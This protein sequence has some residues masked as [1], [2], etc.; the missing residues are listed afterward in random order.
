MSGVALESLYDF[1]AYFVDGEQADFSNLRLHPTLIVNVCGDYRFCQ[2]LIELQMLYT[3]YSAN[4]L[5]VMAFLSGKLGAPTSTI[6]AREVAEFFRRSFGVTFP[7]MAHVEVNGAQAHP[8]FR[9]LSA[10][11][12]GWLGNRKVYNFSKFLVGADGT[13]VRRYASLFVSPQLVGAV[14]TS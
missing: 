14:D 6:G 5:V 2:Q 13:T 4:G 10:K 8:L 12:P 7:I 3:Q 1:E 9:W 11:A